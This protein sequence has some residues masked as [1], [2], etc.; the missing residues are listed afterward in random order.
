MQIRKKLF[1][2]II[3]FSLAL[4][5]NLL[6]LGYLGKAAVDAFSEMN[7]LHQQLANITHMQ[8]QLRGAEAAIYRYM[9][10]GVPGFAEQFDSHLENFSM[11]IETYQL[12]LPASNSQL[13]VSELQ[14][15]YRNSRKIGKDLIH[16]HDQI[17]FDLMALR[18]K[19]DAIAVTI[20]HL[21]KTIPEENKAAHEQLEKMDLLLPEIT[22]LITDYLLYAD[23]TSRTHY[24]ELMIEFHRAYR[25]FKADLD[26]DY[27]IPVTW[28]ILPL[29]T[30]IQTL[31]SQLISLR[32]QQEAFFANFAL[33]MYHVNQEV[34]AEQ[35]QNE[36]TQNLAAVQQRLAKALTTSIA[37]S[38]GTAF[39]IIFVAGLITLPLLRKINRGISTL[40]EGADRIISGDYSTFVKVS[41]TDE[42]HKLAETFNKMMSELQAR[43]AR[44]KM[45]LS[46]LESIRLINLEMTRSLEIRDVLNTIVESTLELVHAAEVHIFICESDRFVPSLIANA[47]RDKDNHPPPRMPRPDGLVATVARKKE[48]IVINEVQQHPVYT[49]QEIEQWGIKA[50]AAF[51]L[52]IDEKATGV[53]YL[54]YDDRTHF[55]DEELWII[56]LLSDQAN[57]ALK[58]ARLYSNLSEKEMHLQNLAQKLVNVQEAE[59]RL[60]GLDLHDGLMQLLLSTNMHLDTLTSILPPMNEQAQQELALTH[61]R[62]KDAIEEVRQVVSDLRPAELEDESLVEGLREYLIRTREMRHWQIEFKADPAKMDMHPDVEIALFRI[63]QEALNNAYR[64]GKAKKVSVHLHQR[65]DA[66][67]LE[68]QDWGRGFNLSAL[69]DEQDHLGVAGMRERAAL[70]GG[71]MEIKSKPGEGTRIVV[72][73]PNP[74]R[75]AG[76]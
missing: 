69:A 25:E 55:S 12:V 67:V 62:L 68:V 14:Q 59:R 41:G 27:Q 29:L 4:I 37:I 65:G 1:V 52:K 45:R 20:D 23:A 16:V 15:A 75:L 21:S 70:L 47:W 42:L 19:Q 17:T 5:V 58:N 35:V 26:D 34:L 51:P 2:L 40:V 49:S 66:V 61:K 33:M 57:I 48:A 60:I 10:E 18:D 63:A 76:V 44:L 13:V 74:N 28:Q 43:E 36:V 32:D 3:L 11:D 73:I 8:A 53:F 30:D 64:H 24:T 56:E 54:S 72:R 22:M 71:T 46:E 6:A 31:G 38:F 50:V 39:L 7:Q 9:M